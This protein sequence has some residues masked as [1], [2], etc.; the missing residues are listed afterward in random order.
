MTKKSGSVYRVKRRHLGQ[1]KIYASLDCL[2]NPERRFLLG[3]LELS[4]T[5]AENLDQE[6]TEIDVTRSELQDWLK[7][8]NIGSSH[9]I[10]RKHSSSLTEKGVFKKLKYQRL[11]CK[12]SD[13]FEIQ[14]AT[15]S[16]TVTCEKS[17]FEDHRPHRQNLKKLKDQLVENELQILDNNLPIRLARSERLWNGV[18]GSCMRFS[19]TDPR[20]NKP[21]TTIYKIGSDQI[22]VVTS[23]QTDSEICHIDDQRTIRVII[24]MVCINIVE[25]IDLGEKVINEFYLD[26]VDLCDLMGLDGSGSNRDTVRDSMKRLYCTNFNLSLNPNSESG[27]KF[28]EQLGITPGADDLNYRFLTEL[29]SSIDGEHGGGFVRR[30]RWYRIA[31]HSKTFQDLIDPSVISTYIDNKE[32]LKT[33][34]GLIHLFYSWCCINVK[35]SGKR[36]IVITLPD[37]QKNR[38]PGARYENFR[39]RFLSAL[40]CHQQKANE[41]WDSQGVNIIKLFGYIVHMEPDASHDFIFTIHRDKR[42]ATIGD[43]SMHNRLLISNSKCFPE[44]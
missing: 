7:V 33:S 26:I 44:L 27:H 24:T 28:A 23:S 20:R 40:K 22:K 8:K 6:T 39:D 29:D 41:I 31:L 42:D 17:K 14:D 18:F 13:L 32:I 30:P 11:K 36:K 37:L 1:L 10:F 4:T 43:G 5:L 38:L 3:L 2:T 15:N 21:F 25:K 34:S 35:R 16:I 12:P 19:R 9:T